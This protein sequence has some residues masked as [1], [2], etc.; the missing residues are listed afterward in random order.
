[1]RDVDGFEM[2]FDRRSNMIAGKELSELLKESSSASN[3]QQQE[4]LSKDIGVGGSIKENS[5]NFQ[6]DDIL[7][8]NDDVAF[9]GD[10]ISKIR[11]V[12]DAKGHAQGMR[13][14]TGMAQRLKERKPVSRWLYEQYPDLFPEYKAEPDVYSEFAKA[15]SDVAVEDD[16]KEE[17]LST[18]NQS[19]LMSEKK[20]EQSFEND[21]SSVL[22]IEKEEAGVRK[23]FSAIGDVI[24]NDSVMILKSP[25]FGDVLF[26]NGSLG[27]LSKKNNGSYGISHIIE[28]RYTKDNLSPVDIASLLYLIKDIVETTEVEIDDSKTRQNIVKNGIWVTLRK[29]FDGIKQNWVVTG[30]A[31]NDSDGHIKKEAADAIKAVNAQ[32]DYTPEHLFVSEQVGAV[33]A[34]LN[35]NIPQN[36]TVSSIQQVEHDNDEGVSVKVETGLDDEDVALARSVLPPLQFNT[37]H[38]DFTRP[39]PVSDRFAIDFIDDGY[40]E[41]NVRFID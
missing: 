39:I 15:E 8:V 27:D 16:K 14:A 33:V 35:L 6:L 26:S 18:D 29:D 36:E 13:V 2:I 37:L 41:K 21:E 11:R 24:K 4:V 1:M 25:S 7:S 32:Y 23:S 10:S 20:S 34:S 30:F 9:D 22:S 40:K 19:L 3:I 31:E 5:K 28:G 17:G 12:L 38:Y